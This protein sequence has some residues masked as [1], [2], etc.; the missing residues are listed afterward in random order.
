LI[1]KHHHGD[2][3]SA[4]RRGWL[5]WESLRPTQVESRESQLRIRGNC[6]NQIYK[7]TMHHTQQTGEFDY[8]I[9]PDQSARSMAS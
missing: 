2:R 6:Q 9:T 3:T 7:E 4:S 1:A 8:F 5:H